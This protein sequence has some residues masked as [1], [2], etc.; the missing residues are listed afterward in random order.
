MFGRIK[1]VFALAVLIA[2]LAVAGFSFQASPE[3]KTIKLP[4][5]QT[6]GGKP[7]MEALKERQSSR[8]FKPE[9]LPPQVLSN[10]LWAADGV[11]R[12]DSGKRTA[13]SA[14]NVQ[15]IDIYAALAEG[16]YLYEPKSNELR[17]VAE[18][19]HRAA[20]GRQEFIKVAP[21]NLVYVADLSKIQRGPEETKLVWSAAHV[22][23]I[24]QNVYLYCASAGLSTVVRGLFD[25]E[26]LGKVLNLR[27]DQKTIL[28]QTV[29]YPE[30]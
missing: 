22:G 8:A 17:L 24:G 29:G 20:T 19:D 15:N 4:P 5:P 10:L 30:K 9:A 16:V 14:M 11:N 2:S 26:E 7:L 12:P 28:A 21:L 18:G 25:S 3:A 1:V 23:F 27:P 6:D 13:P